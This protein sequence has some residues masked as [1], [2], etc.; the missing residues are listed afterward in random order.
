MYQITGY[1]Y[2]R[3]E[4][5]YFFVIKIQ[6]YTQ[7]WRDVFEWHGFY[8]GFFRLTYASVAPF[9]LR[10]F[11]PQVFFAVSHYPDLQEIPFL[12]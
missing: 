8:V 1:H 6:F 10:L 7:R 5:P 3:A 2:A 12:L 4:H 11:G 9:F